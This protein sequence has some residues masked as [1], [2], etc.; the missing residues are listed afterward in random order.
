MFSEVKPHAKFVDIY[1]Q[2]HVPVA[3]LKDKNKI[4]HV[5]QEDDCYVAFLSADTQYEFVETN[6]IFPELH[7]V[8][9]KLPTP[10]EG[11]N[12]AY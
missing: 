10:K 7:A 8:L 2:E 9:A 12:R 5:V 4:C 3:T 11:L 6:Y 1:G